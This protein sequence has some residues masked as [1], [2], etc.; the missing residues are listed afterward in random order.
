MG[1]SENGNSPYNSSI[2]KLKDW[3][4]DSGATDH[5]TYYEKDFLLRTETRKDGI[6]N[7]NGIVY[8]VT[9]ARYVP[10]SK[11]LTLKNTLLVLYLQN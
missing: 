6:Q 2:T 11:T 7:A 3:V 9:G 1:N 5:M 8:P 10:V 4:I